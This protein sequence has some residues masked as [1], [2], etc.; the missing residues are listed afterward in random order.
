MHTHSRIKNDIYKGLINW[1]RLRK[2]LS[3]NSHIEVIQKTGFTGHLEGTNFGGFSTD[4]RYSVIKELAIESSVR[5]KM[6]KKWEVALFYKPISK[7][8]SY[9]WP[10]HIFEWG[11]ETR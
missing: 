2:T 4:F 8:F 3:V 5:K 11:N 9:R 6:K 10:L 1:Q 7:I